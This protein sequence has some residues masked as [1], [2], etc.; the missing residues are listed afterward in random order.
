MKILTALMFILSLNM[1]LFVS[2][3]GLGY[4]SETET[5]SD[6]PIIYNHTGSF[7]STFDNGK[8]VINENVTTILPSGQ[9]QIE[10]ES[11][12]FFTDSF[13]TM[14]NWFLE[15]TGLNYLLGIVTAFPNFLKSVGFPQE[16]SFVLGVI[17]YAVSLFLV[18]AVIRGNY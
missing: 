16:I 8:Y 10:P 15:S 9:G 11:G 2:Q 6:L 3:A 4:I 1:Y 12:N 5:I 18:I 17:W 13:A 14:K 7:I